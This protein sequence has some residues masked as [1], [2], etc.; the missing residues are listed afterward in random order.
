VFGKI[1]LR[2]IIGN[3]FLNKI[4]KRNEAISLQESKL[5]QAKSKEKATPREDDKQY[6]TYKTTFFDDYYTDREDYQEPYNET[7][8][9]YLNKNLSAYEVDSINF[10]DI[11]IKRRSIF[12]DSD[13]GEK[14]FEFVNNRNMQ[15]SFDYLYVIQKKR[16]KNLMKLQAKQKQIRERERV[17][18]AEEVKEE[19]GG[20]ALV[21]AKE[22][23][24][25]FRDKVLDL[26][27]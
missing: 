19:E 14:D 17:V 18:E 13:L 11:K 15:D 24:K 4:V 8:F 22:T 27:K 26:L 10:D 12:A 5:K 6:A 9:D 1:L 20:S 21:K 16:E 25:S 23:V 7:E 2:N 3:F